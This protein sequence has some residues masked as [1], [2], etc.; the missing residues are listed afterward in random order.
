MLGKYSKSVF[1]HTFPYFENPFG[2]I[3]AYMLKR[4]SLK[5][6]TFPEINL[7]QYEDYF[8]L[9]TAFQSKFPEILEWNRMQNNEKIPIVD[10]REKNTTSKTF[11]FKFLFPSIL[12]CYRL[13]KV[14][15]RID[16]KLWFKFTRYQ[17]RI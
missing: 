17:I 4:K 3:V 10:T 2:T 5:L 13:Q 12:I 11:D 7:K 9:P 1:Q 14:P 8:Y 6:F 15:G 16:S